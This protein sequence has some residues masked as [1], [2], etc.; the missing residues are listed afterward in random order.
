MKPTSFPWLVLCC[1]PQSNVFAARAA[2]EW[3]G[4]R[5]ELLARAPVLITVDDIITAA[6]AEHMIKVA[7]PKMIPSWVKNEATG[8]MSL[9]PARTSNTY[10]IPVGPLVVPS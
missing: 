9:H 5:V 2:Y 8:E 10:F 1:L 3:E 4:R 6:E 7:E